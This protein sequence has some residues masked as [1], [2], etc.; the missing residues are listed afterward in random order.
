MQIRRGFL[1]WGIF[2]ILVGAIP[3]AVRGGYISADDLG[4]LFNLWPLILIGI[5]VGLV[6]S[7]TRF[8]FIGGLI[9]AA[10]I[11]IMVGGLLS[12]GVSGFS[13]GSCGSNA[14]ATPFPARDG[15]FGS[16]GDVTL[17]LD[18]GEMT[19]GAAQGSNWHLDGSDKDGSGPTVR[20]DEST[21]EVR[22]RHEPGTAWFAFGDRDTWRL[23]L[24][25]AATLGLDVQVNAGR[26]TLDLAGATLGDVRAQVNA[27]SASF[28]LGSVAA[29]S[30]VDLRLNAGS[31][32]VTLP[33]LS[34]TG[35]I[36]ANAGS[37]QLCVPAGAGIRLRTGQS[38]FANYDYAGHG[39]VQDGSTWTTPGFE[40]AAVK[41]DLDTKANAGS[42]TLDPEDG[43]G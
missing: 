3:L 12:V 28:G 9:V 21:L 42:F 15:A 11:G 26:G 30:T 17:A 18:C 10:T 36:Q 8:D 27:G 25:A 43:C 6:L 34:V 23:T 19:V 38:V 39:L 32:G 20:S 31:L 2:L 13:A 40:S 1:G 22:S 33:N 41:I 7:R 35:S 37:V 24:P 4:R 29:I 16:T 14:T 5:G